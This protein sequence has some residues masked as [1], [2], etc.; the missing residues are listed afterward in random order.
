MT[1]DKNVNCSMYQLSVENQNVNVE[2]EISNDKQ[3]HVM[4]T[5]H[6][7]YLFRRKGN[8]TVIFT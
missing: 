7:P 2:A 3:V 8:A 4:C 1:M 6:I 5:K